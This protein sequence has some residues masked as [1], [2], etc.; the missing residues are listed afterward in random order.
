[1][2]IE[3]FSNK[4]SCDVEINFYKKELINIEGIYLPSLNLHK[5]NFK[6]TLNYL[7]KN[8]HEEYILN[9][10]K[11]A[12][13]DKNSI[14]IIIKSKE[15]DSNIAA[16]IRKLDEHCILKSVS[17]NHTTFY[18]NESNIQIHE[19]ILNKIN[20]LI[21]L[22]KKN[23]QKREQLNAVLNSI[24]NNYKKTGYIEANDII[25]MNNIYQSIRGIKN[26]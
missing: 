20:L 10:K 17:V 13:S 5:D 1:M 22:N 12:E 18:D 26:E 19:N 2:I 4:L 11:K 23:H 6:A 9:N 7:N 25:W 8:K 16:I 24:Y 3:T 21:E 15:Y 14:L